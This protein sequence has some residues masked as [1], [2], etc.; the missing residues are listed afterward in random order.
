LPAA[1][2]NPFAGLGFLDLD[3]HVTASKNFSRRCGDFGTGSPI[4]IVAGHD[5][6][7]SAGLHD[8]LMTVSDIFADRAR[9][10]ANTIFMN[11]DFARDANKN[12]IVG[13]SI[14]RKDST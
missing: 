6:S 4:G 12:S 9:G 1:K 7:A 13:P 14:L 3:D 10:K 11:F 5:A 2:L 8:D